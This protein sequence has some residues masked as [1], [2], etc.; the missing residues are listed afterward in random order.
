MNMAFDEMGK[1]GKG[2]SWEK[3]IFGAAHSPSFGCVRGTEKSFFGFSSGKFSSAAPSVAEGEAWKGLVVACF[4]CCE[5]VERDWV[6]CR[7]MVET[8]KRADAGK[9]IHPDGLGG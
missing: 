5:P 6:T 3:A 2:G 8:D 4:D 7:S 1:I 9:I